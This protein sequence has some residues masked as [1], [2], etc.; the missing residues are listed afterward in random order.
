MDGYYDYANNQFVETLFSPN[1]V[2]VDNYVDNTS[3]KTILVN[4]LKFLRA[5]G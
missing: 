2:K 5:L 3:D 1:N 4:D